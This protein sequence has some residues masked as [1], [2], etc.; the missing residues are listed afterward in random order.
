MSARRQTIGARD[1]PAP[2]ASPAWDRTSVLDADRLRAA[3]DHTLGYTIGVEEELMLLDPES[4][5]LAPHADAVLHLV[6]SDVR[7]A[8]ELR[9][10]QLEIITR[11]CATATDVCRELADARRH[12]VER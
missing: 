5:D 12:L 8:R 1:P 10:A 7:F 6:D 2:V 3:F 4:F 9:A 11:V